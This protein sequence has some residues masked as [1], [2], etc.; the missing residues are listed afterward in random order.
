MFTVKDVREILKDADEKDTVAVYGS[1]N[2]CD[3]D[4]CSVYRKYTVLD[5]GTQAK[6]TREIKVQ[7]LFV[8]EDC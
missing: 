1:E 2:Q 6:P 3:D 4:I 7:Y 5:K 8:I